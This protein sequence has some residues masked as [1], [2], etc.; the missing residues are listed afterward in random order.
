MRPGSVRIR[1]ANKP[2]LPGAYTGKG[3][4]AM[5]DIEQ[6]QIKVFCAIILVALAVVISVAALSS[7]SLTFQA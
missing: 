2:V 6:R 3:V 5:N 4:L 1:S 7:F